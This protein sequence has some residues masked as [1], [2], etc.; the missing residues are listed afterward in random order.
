[1]G[2]ARAR[3]GSA[4][5]L[6]LAIASCD[7]C[8]GHSMYLSGS[9]V[10]SSQ[11]FCNTERADRGPVSLSMG[12]YRT[13]SLWQSGANSVDKRRLKRA[14]KASPMVQG[15]VRTL[16]IPG[17]RGYLR[18]APL[19]FGKKKL[20]SIVLMHY[21]G[22]EPP[23]WDFT[24][25]TIFGSKISGNTRDAVG[26]Y[27]FYFGVWE[28]N[29]TSWIRRRLAPGDVFIDVGA[30]IGYYS[31]LASRL[32]GNS[33]KVVAV[34]V[35]PAIFSALQGNLRKNDVHNVRA[36]NCAVWDREQTI[37][38]FTDAEDL[39]GQTTV[40]PTWADKYHLQSHVQV[41]AAPLS[42]IL[43]AEEI[44]TAR[45]IKIDVEGAEWQVV[46]GM[47]SIM[48]N[49]RDDVEIALEVN[50]KALAAVGRSP[51]DVMD[52]FGGWG[53][54]PYRIENDYL[55]ERYLF[56]EPP[57]PPER[58]REISGDQADIIFSRIDAASL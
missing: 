1:L 12:L 3:T 24:V 38:V 10:S 44:K 26:R 58:V 35:L 40:S 50:K 9:Q 37:T 14:I 32:V 23:K 18:Y 39:P 43:E 55:A 19:D 45:L 49:C 34:E 2:Q 17:A 46:S 6:G 22:L 42:T 27:I 29:L 57:C 5:T 20:W 36:V 33:G 30:N 48:A 52:L 16:V 51:Q 8:A 41:S 28:P 15:I 47:K 53:F 54:R 11:R 13:D 21:L 4:S 56:R 7:V 31:L 25:R